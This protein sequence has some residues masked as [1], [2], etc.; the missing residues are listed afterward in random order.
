MNLK[1]FRLL[2]ISSVLHLSGC[3]SGAQAQDETE[4]GPI[5]CTGFGAADINV[6]VRDSLNDDALIESAIVKVT[7]QHE[8]QEL[9]EDAI[10]TPFDDN[11]VNTL[12]GAYYSPLS[13]NSVSFEISIVVFADGYHSFVTKGINFELNTGCGA[14]NSVVY[15]AYLCPIGT[16]CL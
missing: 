7:S 15:N 3:G 5:S 10:F 4:E 14:S 6:Y 2:I 9:V 1:L 11:I 12:T 16:S 13:F 8:N